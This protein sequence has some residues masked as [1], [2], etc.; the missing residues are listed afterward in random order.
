MHKTILLLSLIIILSSCGM[1]LQEVKEKRDFCE[2]N[3][4]VFI[5]YDDYVFGLDAQCTTPPPQR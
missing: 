3:N 1:T 4:L 2:K 5:L